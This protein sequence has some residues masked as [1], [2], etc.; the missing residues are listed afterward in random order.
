M[1][2]AQLGVGGYG[3]WLLIPALPRGGQLQIEESKADTTK[4]RL[5]E[6]ASDRLRNT[7]QLRAVQGAENIR[8][9][10]DGYSLWARDG[11]VTV[12]KLWEYY[13]QYP[14]MPR[15]TERSVL[16]RGI[17]AVFDSLTW[18]NTASRSLPATTRRP[19]GTPGSRSRT[20]THCPSSPTPPC[21]SSRTRPAPSE[22]PNAPRPPRRHEPPQKQPP[23]WA[24]APPEPAMAR[25]QVL[26]TAPLPE[27]AR[28]QEPLRANGLLPAVSPRPLPRTQEHAF[29]RHPAPEPGTLRPGY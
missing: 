11:H 21:S 22:T 18:E 23:E 16:E 3:Q 19:A 8:L 12:G 6:R 17:L 9:N 28:G 2:A 14:Y 25:R 27:A 1:P 13:C 24:A 5:A 15:L 4:D 29:L 20:K 26:A 10:L 7:D